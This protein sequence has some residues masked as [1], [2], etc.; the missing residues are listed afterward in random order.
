ML[1]N[2]DNADHRWMVETIVIAITTVMTTMMIY[3]YD[4]DNDIEMG[5]GVGGGAGGA[6]VTRRR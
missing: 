6:R 3:G 5:G 2:D 4:N 1:I